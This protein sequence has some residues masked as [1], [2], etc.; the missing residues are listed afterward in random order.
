MYVP[1]A[2]EEGVVVRGKEYARK[3]SAAGAMVAGCRMGEGGG[4]RR[5]ERAAGSTH[6][7]D[8]ILRRGSKC[9]TTNE[10]LLHTKSQENG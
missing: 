9:A 10:L 8:T 6:A 7:H 3:R 1:L 4:W 2:A 5:T